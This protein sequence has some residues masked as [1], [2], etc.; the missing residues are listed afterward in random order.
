MA[1]ELEMDELPELQVHCN[2]SDATVLSMPYI[3]LSRQPNTSMPVDEMAG[4]DATPLGTE[5]VQIEAPVNALRATTARAIKNHQT[6]M[7]L[8][9]TGY[10]RNETG[11]TYAARTPKWSQANSQ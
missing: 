10:R 3:L 9:G 1:G 5:N 11:R 2:A 8:N 4:A 6:Q 7:M